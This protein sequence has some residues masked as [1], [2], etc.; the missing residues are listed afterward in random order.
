MKRLMEIQ[1]HLLHIN[2]YTTQ[3]PIFPK[4]TVNFHHQEKQLYYLKYFFI[5]FKN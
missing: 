2:K 1:S 4:T 5:S 3:S